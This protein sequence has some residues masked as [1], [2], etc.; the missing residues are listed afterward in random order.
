MSEDKTRSQDPELLEHYAKQQ[1]SF[2]EVKAAYE[3][4]LLMNVDL[5]KR[6]GEAQMLKHRLAFLEDW[7]ESQG[8]GNWADPDLF[9]LEFVDN[10]EMDWEDAFPLTD[11]RPFRFVAAVP[12]W[13]YRDGGADQILLF[14]DP[15]TRVAPADVRME[16]KRAGARPRR[17]EC[18]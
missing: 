1:Q 5:G 14:Y 2:D 15:Q 13:N 18:M 16:L 3:R 8:A 9:P 17:K 4:G 10:P 12:G 11:G 7:K 6:E